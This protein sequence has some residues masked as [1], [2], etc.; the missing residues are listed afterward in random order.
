MKNK[1]Y[2][3]TVNDTV[4]DLLNTSVW[5]TWCRMLYSLY[6]SVTAVFCTQSIVTVKGS[7][8]AI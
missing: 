1:L 8:A 3:G 4:A 7:S 6:S 2:S 5:L